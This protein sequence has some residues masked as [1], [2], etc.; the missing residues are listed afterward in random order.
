M[1]GALRQLVIDHLRAHPDEAFTATKIS[2]VIEKSSGAIANAL[3]KLVKD[4]VADQ[5]SDRPGTYRMAT[6][7]DK[8]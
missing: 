2:R 8:A 6:P 7:N 5:M 3:D 1:P 4:G